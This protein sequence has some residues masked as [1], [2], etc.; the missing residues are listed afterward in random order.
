[1]QER[2][3]IKLY[4]LRR[5]HI[6]VVSVQNFLRF[7]LWG[8]WLSL[9]LW[10]VFGL[11]GLEESDRSRA[12]WAWPGLALLG[13]AL[14]LLR[15]ASLRAVAHHADRQHGLQERLL[16]CLGHLQEGRPPSVVSQLLLEETLDKVKDLDPRHT[17]PNSWARPLARWLVPALGLLTLTLVLPEPS[18][19]PDD[20]RDR[21]LRES[22]QRLSETARRLAARPS[23]AA[24]RD[25]QRQLRRLQ[26]QVPAQAARQL[27]QQVAQLEQRLARQNELARRV[28]QL[29]Q[30]TSSEE[31][32]KLSRELP[33]L[34]QAEKSLSA[35]QREAAQK[36]IEQAL[37][38]LN[39][40][41]QA[42]QQ[43]SQA[44][45]QECQN[46]DTQGKSQPGQ[47]S[48]SSEGQASPQSGAPQPGN[49]QQKSGEGPSDFGQGSTNQEEGQTREGQA[50]AQS[51]RLNQEQRHKTEAYQRLYATQR[52]H[53]ETQT[54][55]V[56]LQGGRGRLLRMGDNQL[57]EARN[58]P[59][60]L[61]E[62]ETFLAAKAQ[63]EQSVAEE[64]IPSAHRDAVRR[65]FQEID[66]R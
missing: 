27:R 13:F 48:M 15:P 38:E 52:Q 23:S 26:H 5:R 44:I 18:S 55:Q 20:P 22:H 9:G 40:S 39:R 14:G 30:H 21:Q 58:E 11:A 56:G 8:G 51:D 59:S 62:Q 4:Q 31:L 37:Q 66:P 32:Q 50:K 16:T 47:G 53:L 7:G 29:A 2:L 19:Q 12:L 28:G 36:A 61:P 46:L 34:R 43:L 33:T 35:G 65:Y 24:L 25:L 63:A 60:L 49:H 57:G 10:L 64:R 1:M 41:N 17:Y 42:E 6:W 45:Q 54:R 3:Y